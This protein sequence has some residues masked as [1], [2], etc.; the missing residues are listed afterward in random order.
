MRFLPFLVT[1]FSKIV[2]WFL[3]FPRS[4]ADK[5]S[6]CKCRRPDSI[7]GL[8]RSPGGGHGSLL[9]YSCLENAY[10]LRGLVGYSPWGCKELDTTEQLNTQDKV[11]PGILQRLPIYFFSFIMSASVCLYLI[12]SVVF[13]DTQVALSLTSGDYFGLSWSHFEMIPVVFIIL[14][15]D[16]IRCFRL[17]FYA[18]C[19][20]RLSPES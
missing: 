20:K 18:S 13:I 17:I 1:S 6:T 15:S 19:P 5:E 7:P 2:K 4:S 3:A 10:G 16:I 14:L 11:V 12:L 9:Q 8:G